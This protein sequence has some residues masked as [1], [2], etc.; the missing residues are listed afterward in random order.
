MIRVTRVDQSFPT[1]A[2]AGCDP[3]LALFAGPLQRHDPQ[4]GLTWWP[5]TNT[6]AIE[7]LESGSIHVAGIHRSVNSK[8]RHWPGVETVGLASWSEGLGVSPRYRDTV[9]DLRDV[10]RLGLRIANREPGSEARR[11]LDAQLSRLGVSSS[12]ILGYDTECTAHLLVASAISSGLADVGVT[13]E[14]AALAYDLAYIEWQQ[15][16]SELHIPRSMMDVVEVRALLDVLVGRELP[17]QLAA[18]EGY[19]AEPCGRIMAS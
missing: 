10:A 13:T 2:I 19:D 4:V 12:S 17:V 1:L 15:E 14:P 9:R 3:A 7:M 5:C 16:V 8:S 6:A 18:L 11:L